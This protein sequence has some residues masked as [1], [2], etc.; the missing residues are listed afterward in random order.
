MNDKIGLAAILSAADDYFE[1][2]GRRLTFEYVLLADINDSEKDAYQLASLLKGRPAL[3]NVIPYN[4]VQ[5]LPY[6][7]PSQAA[8][9][10][11]GDIL[12]NAGLQIRF[13]MRKGDKIN[14]ACGQL[15]RIEV[16]SIS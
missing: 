2:S 16:T 15:R 4:P 8:Q 5:G 12:M 10:R 1:A 6:R 3:L 11:F 9:K 14:A 13:R 7:T